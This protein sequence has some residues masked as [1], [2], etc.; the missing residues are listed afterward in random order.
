VEVP[1]RQ[2]E[3]ITANEHA[4]RK[5]ISE[6]I[7]VRVNVLMPDQAVEAV[8]CTP[9]CLK[10]T[11]IGGNSERYV[12]AERSWAETSA[13]ERRTGNAESS[14][15]AC[16]NKAA[17]SDRRR[18]G[19]TGRQRFQPTSACS[20]LKGEAQAEDWRLRAVCL[21]DAPESEE[22]SVSAERFNHERASEERR[23]AL[24]RIRAIPAD[25]TV[26]GMAVVRGDGPER[27]AT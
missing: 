27:V 19:R 23:G 24:I 20:T 2:H 10:L 17:S 7:I 6:R 26:T 22:Q 11:E 21:R 16:S 12:R 4:R 9:G 1:E 13:A 14:G 5:S 8:R 15:R 18:H 25:G 3:E